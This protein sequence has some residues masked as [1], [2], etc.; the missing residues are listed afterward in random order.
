MLVGAGLVRADGPCR[1]ADVTPERAAH[2]AGHDARG[3]DRRIR[4]YAR[5]NARARS[6]RARRRALR[7]RDVAVAADRPR[8]CGAPHGAVSWTAGDSQQ[9]QRADPRVCRHARRIAARRRLS[10]RRVH[11]RVRRRS[12]LRLRAG[13]RRLRRRVHGLPPGDQGAGAAAGE[14]GRRSGAGIHRGG[15][16]EPRRSSRGSTCTTRTRRTIRRRPTT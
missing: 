13:V 15:A 8:A 1:A 10:H 9:R 5:R 4:I 2:H 6:P 12:R 7:R 11:R 14:R 16:G 3:P